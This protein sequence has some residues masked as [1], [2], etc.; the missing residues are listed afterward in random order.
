MST[1]PSAPP[2]PPYDVIVIGAGPSGLATAIAASKA[3]LRAVVVEKGA[4]VNSLLHFPTDMVFF[5]TPELLEIG[6]LPFVSPHEKPTRQEALKYYRRVTDAFEL[7]ITFDDA[8]TGI[9]RDDDGAFAVKS[10]QMIRRAK[11]VVIATGA[12]D[13]A[14]RLGIPGED[15]PHVSHYYREPH[16]FYRRRVVVVG[17]KNSAAEAALDLYRNGVAVTLV[18]RGEALGESIKYWVKPDIENRIKEGTITAKFRTRVTAITATDVEVEGPDGPGRI[19][20]DGVLLLTGY[21]SDTTLLRSIGA[22]IDESMGAPLDV[23]L[24]RKLGVPWQPELAFGAIAEAAGTSAPVRVIDQ[25]LVRECKLSPEVVDGIAARE[26]HEIGRRSRLY[27]GTRSLVDIHGKEVILVDD[28]VATGSTMLAAVRA[29]RQYIAKRIVVAV[30]VGPPGTCD[31]LRREAGEVV[32]LSSPEP[33][34]S[35][36][37]WYENFT[38]I[39]DREVQRALSRNQPSAGDRT[40]PAVH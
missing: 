5:T 30:P 39:T 33:F 3:G 36:G 37:T 35:V 23:F 11:A 34:Y 21:R 29:L 25:G 4:L 27:R 24:V 10:Q 32:C 19:P 31:A 26:Q 9:A 8:V 12:Y 18:H 17:G 40:K 14:N 20:A 28:G 1:P 6:G 7:E 2:P 15:L 16:P 38:Q 13:I 22:A